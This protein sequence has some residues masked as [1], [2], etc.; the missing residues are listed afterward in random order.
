[1]NQRERQN[2]FTELIIRH[3]SE[4]YGYIYA[5]VKNWGDTDDL[6]QSVCLL[7]WSKFESFQPG[8]S[9]FAWARQ[10]A[11]IKVSNFLRHKHSLHPVNDNLINILT[12][13]PV[14]PQNDGVEPYL[15]VLRQ[16]REKLSAA[17]DELLQLRYVEELGTGEIADRLQRFQSNV[18]RSLNRIRRQLFECIQMELARQEHSQELS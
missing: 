12:D 10:T 1:M 7:L 14:E 17:D 2:L 15:V 9:F 8:T 5:V 16:C 4:L 13:I 11:K 3:Q 6:F 18:C